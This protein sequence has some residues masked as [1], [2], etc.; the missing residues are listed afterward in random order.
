[1]NGKLVLFLICI[2]IAFVVFVGKDVFTSLARKNDSTKLNNIVQEGYDG[3]S[4]VAVDRLKLIKGYKKIKHKNSLINGVNKSEKRYLKALDNLLREKKRLKERQ[5]NRH[6]TKFLKTEA[7]QLLDSGLEK[8]K[9]GHKQE[10]REYIL[11]ALDMHMNF[12]PA[13]YMIFLKTL[14]HAYVGDE[15]KKQIDQSVLRY[16]ALIKQEYSNDQLAMY[17]NELVDKIE[18]KIND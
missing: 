8:L 5:E 10:A 16:L 3:P 15:D 11:Q 9:L 6:I 14:I 18:E 4:K 13:I 1:M 2:V 12:D 7:G 17:V